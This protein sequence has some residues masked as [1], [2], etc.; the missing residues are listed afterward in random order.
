[1]IHGK[2]FF[3]FRMQKRVRF[4]NGTHISFLLWQPCVAA[5]QR[6]RMGDGQWRWRKGGIMYSLWIGSVLFSCVS[7]QA[8]G[9]DVGGNRCAC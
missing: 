6:K 8:G 7:C 1:M 3:F 5:W 4:R 2:S 9:T